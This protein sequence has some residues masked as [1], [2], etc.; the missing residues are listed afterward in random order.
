MKEQQLLEKIELLKSLDILRMYCIGIGCT[1]QVE[2]V[3]GHCYD[4]DPCTKYTQTE[5]VCVSIGCQTEVLEIIYP[6]K[7][8]F[9]GKKPPTKPIKKSKI[10]DE[11]NYVATVMQRLEKSV[12]RAQE[13]FT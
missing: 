7:R 5:T 13:K 10:G 4:H 1:K 11:I 3:L 2:R 6:G 12:V 9:A 8:P